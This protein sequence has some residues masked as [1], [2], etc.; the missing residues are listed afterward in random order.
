MPHANLA[1]V[2]FSGMQAA[3]P[4]LQ[5]KTAK[6][7]KKNDEDLANIIDTYNTEWENFKRDNEYE[8]NSADYQ[9]KI[10]EEFKNKFYGE[11]RKKN[12][13]QY[14]QE[15]MDRAET[16]FNETARRYLLEQEDAWR[17]RKE[18]EK[19]ELD[20]M[21]VSVAFV[22]EWNNFKRDNPYNGNKNDY[23]DKI[24]KFKDDFF[25]RAREK[26]QSRLFQQGIDRIQIKSED[27]ALNHLLEQEDNWR[28][29]QA[30]EDHKNTLTKIGNSG[31]DIKTAFNAM[32]TEHE[33]FSNLYG[34]T[35]EA[36]T[37]EKKDIYGRFLNIAL[38]VDIGEAETIKQAIDRL[39][40]RVAAY[41]KMVDEREG[42]EGALDGW[43]ANKKELLAEA[44]KSAR[45]F[46]WKRNYGNLA[47]MDNEYKRIAQDAV[48][49]NDYNL[50]RYALAL[51]REGSQMR[52][53][54][55]ES[56]E[57]DPEDSSKINGMFSLVRGLTDKESGTGSGGGSTADVINATAVSGKLKEML[58]DVFAGRSLYNVNKF[59]TMFRS[60]LYKWAVDEGRYGKDQKAFEAEFADPLLQFWDFAKERAKEVP[61]MAKAV[62]MAERY[63]NNLSDNNSNNDLWLDTKYPGVTAHARGEVLSGL[64]D[65]IFSYDN[66]GDPM[67]K[68]ASFLQTVT[69]MLGVVTGQT[70]KALAEP[71]KVYGDALVMDKLEALQNPNIMHTDLQGRLITMPGPEKDP[72][73]VKREVS[74]A[75][76]LIGQR[77]ARATGLDSSKLVGHTSKDLL[78]NEEDASPEFQYA[79]SSNWYRLQVEGE[80][81]NRKLI[82]EQRSGLDGTWGNRR[83]LDANTDDREAGAAAGKYLQARNEEQARKSKEWNDAGALAIGGYPMPPEFKE[84]VGDEYERID[85]IRKYGIQNYINF[86]KKRGIEVPGVI[87]E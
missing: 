27:A 3:S 62:D 71:S 69:D 86:L 41:E 32:M 45:D 33:T 28:F 80:G 2:F 65:A 8:G 12:S 58:D 19:T 44:K 83:V 26:S 50:R 11:W 6:L 64:W 42:S 36:R 55:L 14:F 15:N 57:Y 51:W 72:E 81:R 79:G 75:W 63:F 18:N 61:D 39:D 25:S 73:M 54:A 85:F 31:V 38:G 21:N 22:T 35:P 29:E 23:E 52:E 59:S 77:I 84:E 24:N 7:K 47:A 13:S 74:T 34:V 66:R 17:L 56:P 60:A 49:S 46:I 48:R 10:E 1:D 37:K 78:N 30:N 9:I 20:L 16:G 87:S 53:A 4:Y 40:S 82:L 76:N 67:R 70:I 5:Y 68:G 43:V